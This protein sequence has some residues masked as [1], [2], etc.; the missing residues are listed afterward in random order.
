MYEFYLLITQKLNYIILEWYER[1][2]PKETRLVVRVCVERNVRAL[3][4]RERES[5]NSWNLWQKAYRNRFKS[6]SPWQ[7][8][9]VSWAVCLS[10]WREGKRV[11]NPLSLRSPPP[12]SH[13]FWNFVV[14]S[15]PLSSIQNSRFRFR[16]WFSSGALSD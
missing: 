12:L 15:D 4:R 1:K 16:D 6:K 7:G 2:S 9:E 10:S 8:D 13:F 5:S 11:G 14:R 3:E